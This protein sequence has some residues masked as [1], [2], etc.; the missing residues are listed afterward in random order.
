MLEK[1]EIQERGFRNVLEKGTV[2]GF[3]VPFRLTTYR[4]LWLSQLTEA[5]VTVNGEKFEGEQITW[6][7][8][9]KTFLQKELPNNS[10]FHWS[11][12]E[13]CIFNVKKPG[14]L[15][16][17][18]YDVEIAFGYTSSYGPYPYADND[19]PRIQTYKRNMTLAG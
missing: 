18:I 17:G 7:I 19:M 14:G 8:H 5:T 10:N 9:G 1:E 11:P 3:Q 13:P 15:K 12:L 16:L 4:G 6:V 2:V